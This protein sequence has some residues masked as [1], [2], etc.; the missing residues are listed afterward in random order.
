MKRILPVLAILLLLLSGCKKEGN[1]SNYIVNKV[2]TFFV[3]NSGDKT[4]QKSSIV[5]NNLINAVVQKDTTIAEESDTVNLDSMLKGVK[6]PF[7]VEQYSFKS[8]GKRDIFEPLLS[9]TKGT[10]SLNLDNAVL[11]GIIEGPNGRVALIKEFGGQGYVLKENDK[12]AD[13][14]VKKIGEDYIIFE[15]HQFGVVSETKFK[16]ESEDQ[17]LKF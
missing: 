9:K 11:T 5:D 14:Y 1:L 15:T 10:E 8:A 16:L 12:I 7:N 2:V 17:K 4:V 3:G 6:L 13:G